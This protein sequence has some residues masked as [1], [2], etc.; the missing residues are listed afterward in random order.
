RGRTA[1]KK[2]AAGSLQLRPAMMSPVRTAKSGC[3]L[4]KTCAISASV[5]SFASR[6]SCR[7]K[8]VNWTMVKVPSDRK[9][10]DRGRFP[11][12]GSDLPRECS[13]AGLRRS[14]RGRRSFAFDEPDAKPL[15]LLDRKHPRVQVDHVSHLGLPPQPGEEKTAERVDAVR[16]L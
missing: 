16:E 3:S 6:L 8:S 13:L 12:T 4:S 11:S 15:A 9:R 2:V 10:K 14:A 5:R 7:C 1:S